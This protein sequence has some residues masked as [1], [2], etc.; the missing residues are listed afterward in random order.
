MSSYIT[1]SYASSLSQIKISTDVPSLPLLGNSVRPPSPP[2]I[3]LR[4]CSH[5]NSFSSEQR[6]LL[7]S[8][9]REV[10]HY[11]LCFLFSEFRRVSKTETALRSVP[12]TRRTH[13]RKDG[14]L[15]IGRVVILRRMVSIKFLMGCH[16]IPSGAGCLTCVREEVGWAIRHARGLAYSL[17]SSHSRHLIVPG[18]FFKSLGERF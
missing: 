18:G 2:A 10:P 12:V 7:D 11:I 15:M 9:L 5:P 17:P 3:A 1:I 8:S 14:R 4:L 6:V 16:S 13:R